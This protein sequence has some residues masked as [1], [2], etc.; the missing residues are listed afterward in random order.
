MDLLHI[1]AVIVIVIL[2]I[3]IYRSKKNDE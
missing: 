3:M 2:G 1:A